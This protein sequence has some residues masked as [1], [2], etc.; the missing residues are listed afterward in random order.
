M[1]NRLDVAGI[2]I[3]LLAVAFLGC[4]ETG[5]NEVAGG[6]FETSDLKAQVVDSNGTPVSSARVWLLSEKGNST[7]AKALDSLLSDSTGI[8]R[9]RLSD[10]LT[11]GLEA[12]KGDSLGVVNSNVVPPFVSP[13]RLV[14]RPSRALVLRCDSF[15]L[16]RLLVAGSHFIQTPPP[17]CTDSFTVIFPSGPQNLLD[18]PPSGAPPRLI[19]VLADSLPFWGPNRPPPGEGAPPT[20]G[21]PGSP[22]WPPGNAGH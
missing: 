12:W 10:S 18:I 20:T 9:F 17:V 14:L 8:V 21:G 13:V 3:A 15:G 16:H 1:K 4:S 6:G 5:S 2:A 11:L 19:P 22:P 7:A